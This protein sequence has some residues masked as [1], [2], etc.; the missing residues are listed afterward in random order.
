MSETSGPPAAESVHLRSQLRQ[1]LS[2][3]EGVQQ[4]D[5]GEDAGQFIIYED[6]LERGPE[7]EEDPSVSEGGPTPPEMSPPPASVRWGSSPGAGLPEE[8]SEDAGQLKP[9][10]V[11]ELTGVLRGRNDSNPVW[12]PTGEVIAFERAVDE[13]KEIV[14]AKRDGSV[15]RKVYFQPTSG[16]TDLGFL[17]TGFPETASYNAGITWS[18]AGDRFVFM[19]NAG[20]GNYDLYLGGLEGESIIR[21]TEGREKEGHAHWSPVSE[22][23]VFVSGRTGKADLYLLDLGTWRTE[24]LTRGEKTYLY[25]QWSPDG[26]KIATIYGSNENHDIHLIED[27]NRPFDTIRPLTTW[28]HDD[29]RPIWSPDG[30]YIA[31]Y[32]NYNPQGD[33][34]TWSIVVVAAD[35]SD[36]TGGEGLAARVVAEGVHP[37]MERGPAWMPDSRRIVFVKNDRHAFFPI[38]VADVIAGVVAPVRTG[39]RI[40]HDVSCSADGSIAFRAQVDQ[41]DRIFISRLEDAGP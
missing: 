31:F 23:L 13:R 3:P 6:L 19:S 5:T 37:D 38:A 14:I 36:P 16:D 29:L 32:S 24:R 22:Q 12:S 18:P 30:K 26:R 17:L 7:G 11:R 39:T 20:K 21:L 8:E 41:W 15:V 28:H 9:L 4:A 10:Y 25:P 40:N 35:G 2:A 33:P 34:K 1:A 27:I